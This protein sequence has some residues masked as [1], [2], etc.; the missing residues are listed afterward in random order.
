MCNTRKI[1]RIA[2]ASTDG[3]TID[4]HFGKAA[5]FLIFET[6]KEGCA[7]IERRSVTPLSSGDKHTE[8][9]LLS[10][11]EALKDCTAVIAV[12]VGGAVKRALEINGISV[13]ERSD[14]VDN[15]LSKLAAYYAKI[16]GGI[17]N[18]D[19]M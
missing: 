1:H 2:A 10:T 15:A 7:C 9:G 11:I 12:K 6:G 13:F 18:E 3:K 14:S 17:K 5:S 16:S 19:G 4:E 8:E